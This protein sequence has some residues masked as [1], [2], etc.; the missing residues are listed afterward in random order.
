MRRFV[1]FLMLGL[2]LAATAGCSRQVI[3]A[4][5]SPYVA[6]DLT[7]RNIRRVAV[8]PV[9]VP[10][11]MQSTG[12]EVVSVEIS[13]ELM[14]KLASQRLFDLVGGAAVR[15]EMLADYGNMRDWIYDGNVVGAVK[16][17]RELKADAV[18]FGRV[19]RYVQSNLSQSEFEVQFDLIEIASMETVWSVRELLIGKGG[20]PGRGGEVTT[21][22]SRALS[23]QA[24]EG[25]SERVAEIYA[26]GGPIEVSTVSQQQIWGYSLV[27]TGTV[28]TV[29]AGYYFALSVQAYQQYRE[30]DSAAELARYR[31]DTED[32]DQMWMI[33]G[34]AGLGLLG[35]GTYL[36]LT[37]PARDLAT[38]ETE[39]TRFTFAPAVTHGALGLSCLGQF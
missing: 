26:A 33:L 35:V 12:G 38:I 9:V 22:S 14:S 34:P 8:L 18:I 4:P 27:T 16:V 19:L 10:N 39:N 30:S 6:S 25:A 21:P 37:D 2:M 23:Q 15:D 28:V 32:F 20:V 5:L 3:R 1:S 24:V 11:Y 31:D 17:G 7:S 36:L 13:N 29:A